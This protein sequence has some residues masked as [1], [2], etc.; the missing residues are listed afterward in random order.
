MMLYE[1]FY[2]PCQRL[3]LSGSPDNEGGWDTNPVALNEF[4]A[5]VVLDTSSEALIADSEGLNRSYRVTSPKGTNLGFNDVFKRVSDGQTFRVISERLD[6]VT[7]PI[8]SFE[9][10]VVKAEAWELP[11]E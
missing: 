4:M 3:Q 6:I 10:E 2:E 9:F 5:A 7:P 11:N 8:S 1:N